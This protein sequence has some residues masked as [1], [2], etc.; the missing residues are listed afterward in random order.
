MPECCMR[1]HVFKE[2]GATRTATVA[3]CAQVLLRVVRLVG[4]MALHRCLSLAL[5]FVFG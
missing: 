5:A 1:E 3:T 2:G 4:V